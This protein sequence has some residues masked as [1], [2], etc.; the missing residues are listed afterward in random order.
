MISNKLVLPEAEIDA[1]NARFEAESAEHILRW[2][3]DTFAPDMVASSSFQTQSVP[4]LHII[5]RVCPALPIL[6]IDTGYHFP[7]TLAFRDELRARYNLN[8]V[9]IQPTVTKSE[10]MQQYGEPLYRHD[11]DLCCYINKVSPMQW[12]TSWVK[13]WVSGVRRDQTAKRKTMRIFEAQPNG[14]LRVHP[15][16]TWTADDIIA[17]RQTHNLPSHPLSQMGYTSIGCAPCTRPVFFG[18]DSRAGR[19]SDSKKTECGLHLDWNK[20]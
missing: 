9:A 1:L 3:W 8:V 14:Q 5:S 11:P 7:Q 12:A 18:E 20:P 17:Y 2:A 19:W 13:V 6:F 16:L 15:L 10:T 4:L